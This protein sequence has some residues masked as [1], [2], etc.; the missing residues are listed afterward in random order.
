MLRG[1]ILHSA[2][3]RFYQQL[4]SAI[5]GADRVTP[6]NV[7]AAVALM[8]TASRRRRDGAPDRRG[9]PRPARARAGA[10]ARPR[11]ARA[12]RGG[13]ASPRSSRVSSRCRSGRS[14]SSPAC[15][16]RQDRPVDGDPMGAPRD[17]RRLQV[18]RGLVG[19][20]DPGRGPP[21]AAALHARPPRPARPGA[22][23]R[24][25]HAGRRRSPPPRDAREGRVDPGFSA[26]RLPRARASS[27]KRST[28]RGPRRSGSS[29][30]SARETSATTPGRR[31][32]ALVR[33]LA[34]VPQ[35]ATVRAETPRT[36]SSGGDRGQ[37]QPFRRRRAQARG[38]PP[39][40]S[41][42]SSARSSTT[43]STSTRFS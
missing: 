41:S 21:P 24:D 37:R 13:V 10:A 17:R 35:G 20:G 29:S 31:V 28:R 6:E 3:Q 36:S 43:A 27:A 8:R 38:R 7:E 40:S 33:P 39:C 4:P 30:G 25:L 34:D 1:S 32:P 15:G 18:G 22:D 2:L 5:P 19:G 26:A 23:R 9:R 16:Q 42:G 14:S 11:A 12:R